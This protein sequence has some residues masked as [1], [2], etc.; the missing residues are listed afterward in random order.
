M[1]CEIDDWSIG[2]GKSCMK[3]AWYFQLQVAV[4]CH[5][6]QWYERTLRIICLTVCCFSILNAST[7]S[8]KII[9]M[10]FHA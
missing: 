7:S 8:F 6:K 1:L 9:S 2:G 4:W 5:C 3:I 10:H